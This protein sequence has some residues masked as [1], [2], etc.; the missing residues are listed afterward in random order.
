MSGH[1]VASLTGVESLIELDRAL[2]LAPDLQKWADE[3]ED[4]KPLR[5]AGEP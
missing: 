3:D 1:E 4:L 5:V 2:E